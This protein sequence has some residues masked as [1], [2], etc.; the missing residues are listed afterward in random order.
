MWFLRN[1]DRFS[2]ITGMTLFALLIMFP[3]DLE[4]QNEFR[5]G[6]PETTIRR[7]KPDLYIPDITSSAT[8]AVSGVTSGPPAELAPKFQP[9][10]TYRFR[11]ELEIQFQFPL[12]GTRLANIEHQSRFDARPRTDG[13]LGIQLKGRTERLK[14][15]MKAPGE[16]VFY[17]SFDAGDRQTPLGMHFNQSLN[18]WVDLKLNNEHRIVS[19][20][21]GGRQASTSPL[22]GFPQ[23]GTSDLGQTATV[24][25]QGMP[26]KPVRPGQSWSVEG[27]KRLTEVGE[28]MLNI[29]CLYRGE[30]AHDHNRYLQIDLSGQASGDVGLPKQESE[31]GKAVLMSLH[32]PRLSGRILYDP[33]EQMVRLSEQTVSMT[34]EIPGG[35]GAS[36]L[37]VPVQQKSKIQL[38]HVIPTP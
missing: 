29:K 22:E 32:V 10:C 6:E 38:L 28:I 17:D 15:E 8:D 33:L 21:V 16:S 36:P 20:D 5:I 26:D 11:S 3:L 30:V 37:I 27:V 35:P 12:R 31:N 14:V 13:K 24:V 9:G 23:L 18:Q 1:V 2:C 7:E 34:V 25:L 4:A 19:E